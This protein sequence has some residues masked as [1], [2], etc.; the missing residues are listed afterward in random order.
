VS[1][2]AV[3]RSLDVE[4]LR[5]ELK[6]FERRYGVDSA[7]RDSAFRDEDGVLRETDDWRDW[8]D[9]YATWQ[10]CIPEPY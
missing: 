2:F 1:L 8:D 9:A 5:L 4:E 6:E 10:R 3:H 7:N